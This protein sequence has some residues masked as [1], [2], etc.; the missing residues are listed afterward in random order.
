MKNILD[1]K[2]MDYEKKICPLET[3]FANFDENKCEACLRQ[4]VFNLKARVCQECPPKMLFNS[5][6]QQ[7]HADT[8]CP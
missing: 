1:T 7:C 6:T 8:S 5:A 4:L 3:P 2:Y